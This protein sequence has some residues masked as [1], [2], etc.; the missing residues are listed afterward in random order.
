MELAIALPVLALILVGT[1]DFGRV[2]WLAMVVQNAAR[3]GAMFG[4][5]NSANAA[6]AAGMRNAGANVLTANGL[7]ATSA[8]T[9]ARTCECATDAGVYGST[10]PI[11]NN[12]GGTATCAVGSH[13][14]V[15]VAVTATKTFSM[16]GTFSPLPANVTI[17]RTA[18]MRVLN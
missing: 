15:N 4:A 11:A 16:T 12:C 18:K 17:V 5:Q 9:A 13:L 3:A 10:L 1:I 7:S 6:N 8:V 14:I 2:F